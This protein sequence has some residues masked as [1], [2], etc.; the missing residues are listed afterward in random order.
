[1]GSVI[2]TVSAARASMG[3]RILTGNVMLMFVRSLLSVVR[4]MNSTFVWSSKFPDGPNDEFE[5]VIVS[6]GLHFNE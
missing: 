4:A 2:W 3:G 5:L 1:M 6:A